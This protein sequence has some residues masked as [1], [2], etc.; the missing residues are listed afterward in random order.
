[1]KSKIKKINYQELV[2]YLIVGVLTTVVSLLSYYII[3]S[4]IL[5]PDNGIE[6]QI[7]NI[8]SWI[9]AVTFAYFANR[10][11][12][13]KSKE[14]NKLKEATKFYVSRLITLAMD[15]GVMYLLVTVLSKNDRVAKLVSQV[16]V[17]IGN[18][19]ISKLFV[20]KHN[21]NK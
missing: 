12:V 8:F 18:Y 7:A 2:A 5:D 21:E 19:I 9:C 17:T 6:L 3:T 10:V 11:Y 14:E 15:M 20:F 1:M 13:F 4:T 16:V